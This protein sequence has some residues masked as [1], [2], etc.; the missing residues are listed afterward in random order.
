MG[1][2]THDGELRKKLV[3]IL[4]PVLFPFV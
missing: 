3:L 2:F 4:A 1:E